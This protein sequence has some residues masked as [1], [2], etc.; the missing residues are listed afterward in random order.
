MKYYLS[1]CA[2][3]RNEAPY[4]EEWIEWHLLMG[5]E[6]FYLYDNNSTDNLIEKLEKYVTRN[7]VTYS[8]ISTVP[9]QFIAYN[10]CL[11]DYR[12]ESRWIAF[13]DVDEFIFLPGLRARVALPEVLAEYQDFA[14]LACH[15]LLFGSLWDAMGTTSRRD[16]DLPLV[17]ERF[18][19]R[20]KSV[21]QHV[22]SIVQP[23]VTLSV[24]R[25]PHTFRVMA[26]QKIVDENKILLPEEYAQVY[27]TANILAIAHYHCKSKEEYIARKKLGDPGSG[28]IPDKNRVE[29][30]FKAHDLN[31]IK[32]S[33]LAFFAPEIERKIRERK[34][35]IL[36]S[37]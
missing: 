20:G 22:K 11:L 12:F 27:G 8:T 25:N 15:W 34:S 28:I 1:V 35:L 17:I 37:L 30:M 4:I 2:V 26:G 7:V 10:K 21:N 6:H 19:W 32:D 24:G 3:V 29:L 16:G 5:V 9:V 31:E 23:L 18:Q 14:I 13:I 33:R 36:D